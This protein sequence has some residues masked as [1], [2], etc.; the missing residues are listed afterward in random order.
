M[1]VRGQLR[2]SEAFLD[3]RSRTLFF[4]SLSVIELTFKKKKKTLL[5][6][7][8]YVFF[9]ISGGKGWDMQFTDPLK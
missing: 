2:V 6:T 3:Y 9:K 7:I 4:I 5:L 8:L 1:G